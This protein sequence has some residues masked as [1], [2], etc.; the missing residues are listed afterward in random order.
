M[1]EPIDEA[2]AVAN[3][4][5]LEVWKQATCAV[6]PFTLQ[7]AAQA[8]AQ[9]APSIATASPRPL[10]L[11]RVAPEAARLACLFGDAV[12]EEAKRRFFERPPTAD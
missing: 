12:A 10:Q 6:L 1:A 7:L 2:Q 8:L 5:L 9:Q 11:E 4:Y 3:G